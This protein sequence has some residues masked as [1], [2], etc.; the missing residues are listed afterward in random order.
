LATAILDNR[1]TDVSEVIKPYAPAALYRQEVLWYSFLLEA[2]PKPD[3]S[4]AGNIIYVFF[5]VYS[6]EKSNHLI[7]NRSRE[8]L[9][10]SIVPQPNT[11]P[12]ATR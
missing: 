6:I 9:A 1:L 4:A 10:F 7:G 2:E 5:Y 8:L 3:H 11:L 12:R